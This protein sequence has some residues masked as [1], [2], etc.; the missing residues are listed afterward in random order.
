V[1]PSAHM[2]WFLMG[3]LFLIAEIFLPGFILI[4]FVA[5]CWITALLLLV[6]EIPFTLQL[7]IFFVTSL[8]MLFF[9]RK[10][11]MKAFES[12]AKYGLEHDAAFSK[13]QKNAMVTKRIT[14]HIPGEIKAMGSYWRA[15]SDSTIDEGTPVLIIRQETED[16]LTFRVE[17]LNKDGKNE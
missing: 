12:R 1:F 4:F 17:L 7:L 3:V 16:G 6:F 8:L 10:Y 15:V 14:P 2:A 5:G 11:C 13:I 9:V